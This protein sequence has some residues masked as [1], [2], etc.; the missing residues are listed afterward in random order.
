[1]IIVLEGID[2]CG[3]GTQQDILYRHLLKAPTG[4]VQK[5]KF[6]DYSTPLGKLIEDMLHKRVALVSQP[7]GSV[8]VHYSSFDADVLGFQGLMTANRLEHVPLL[9]RFK[10]KG[11]GHLVV[12]RYWHSGIAYGCGVDGVDLDWLMGVSMNL[13]QPDI[14]ILV[15][16][17]TTEALSRQKSRGR[18]DRYENQMLSMERARSTYFKLWTTMRN[19][20][21]NGEKV[22]L[23]EI[24]DGAQTPDLV[25][26]HIQWLIKLAEAKP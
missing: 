13:V 3:K 18:E 6:P 16:I 12:D 20:A 26:A 17:P 5:L 14:S 19:R 10:G 9:N 2:G 1:M 21:A 11:N 23:Y 4:P 7:H 15:D 24:V 22:G 8:P 25:A